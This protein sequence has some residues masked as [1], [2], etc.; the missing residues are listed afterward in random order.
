M[1]ILIKKD[2]YGRTTL[3]HDAE[4]CQIKA[5]IILLQR[6]VSIDN[7]DNFG[8]TPRQFSSEGENHATTELLLCEG[9]SVNARNHCN[10]TAFHLATARNNIE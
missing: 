6:G 4:K 5:I 7:R 1:L 8:P 10:R 3:H 2:N 9:A